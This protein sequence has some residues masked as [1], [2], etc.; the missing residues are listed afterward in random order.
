MIHTSSLFANLIDFGI[1]QRMELST[2]I[3]C[4][5]TLAQIPRIQLLSWIAEVSSMPGQTLMWDLHFPLSI[6]LDHFWHSPKSTWMSWC[7]PAVTD[8]LLIFASARVTR[9]CEYSLICVDDTF[10][11][12]LL[13]PSLWSVASDMCTWCLWCHSRTGINMSSGLWIVL[14]ESRMKC[15]QSGLWMIET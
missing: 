9:N 15:P 2:N 11:G 10:W 14:S 4:H 1:G 5:G 13:T 3:D 12:N 6:R 8:T 7:T